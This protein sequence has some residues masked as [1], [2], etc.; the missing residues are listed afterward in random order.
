MLRL[1]GK[2]RSRGIRCCNS[3]AQ[4]HALSPSLGS[5]VLGDSGQRGPTPLRVPFWGSPEARGPGVQH[6][7]RGAFL[8]SVS[9]EGEAGARASG[10]WHPV[11][12]L[13]AG[14]APRMLHPGGKTSATH[15]SQGTLEPSPRQ[16]SPALASPRQPSPASPRGALTPVHSRVPSRESSGH[17]DGG[18]ETS[19]LRRFPCSNQSPPLLRKTPQIRN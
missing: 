3:P 6:G 8:H 2:G 4:I 12:V 9:P 11:P 10:A 15:G 7:G 5:C 13:R 19:C 1:R 17:S 14:G 18:L 16:P